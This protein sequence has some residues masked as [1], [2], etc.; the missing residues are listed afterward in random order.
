MEQFASIEFYSGW[1]LAVEM[2]GAIASLMTP[3]EAIADYAGFLR[4][5]PPHRYPSY[6]QQGFRVCLETCQLCGEVPLRSIESF[7][8]ITATV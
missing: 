6:A 5:F 8:L 2:L 4:E 1:D 7:R 3:D